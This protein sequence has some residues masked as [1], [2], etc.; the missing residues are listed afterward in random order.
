MSDAPRDTETPPP[1][2]LIDSLKEVGEAGRG[3]TR[4]VVTTTS[5]GIKVLCSCS[6]RAVSASATSIALAPGFLVTEIVTAG[7]R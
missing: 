6:A 1:P 7:K 4:V 2:D 3:V 5:A